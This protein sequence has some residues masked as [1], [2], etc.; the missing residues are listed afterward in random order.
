MKICPYWSR[1][2]SVNGLHIALCSSEDLKEQLEYW[3]D[4]EGV[5]REEKCM[6]G[7]AKD[8]AKELPCIFIWE[9]NVMHWTEF[10]WKLPVETNKALKER[11]Y[12]Q[13]WEI[14]LDWARE[15]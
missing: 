12:D 3:G 9:D 10:T 13:A 5:Q 6:F 2:A 14:A 8:D 11:N 1:I 15:K 7:F 4:P